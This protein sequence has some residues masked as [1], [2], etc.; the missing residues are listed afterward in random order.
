M[1]RHHH[2]SEDASVVVARRPRIVVSVLLTLIAVATA[3]GAFA[4]WPHG[5]AAAL[6]PGSAQVAVDGT[7]FPT[8]TV[9]SISPTCAG[10]GDAGAPTAGSGCETATV[11]ILDGDR[12]GTRADVQLQGPLA[13]AGISPGDQVRL[14]IAPAAAQASGDPGTVQDAAQGLAQG[15]AQEAGQGTAQDAVPAPEE[16]GAAT[17]GVS[18][19]GVVRT[20]PFL[21]WAIVFVVIIGLVGR[22]RGLLAIVG[23]GFSG[24]VVAIFT[25]PAL[26]NGSSG[27]A[28]ALVS[29]GAMLYVVLYLAHGV[30][31]RTSAALAGTLAG[32][33]ITAVIAQLAIVST[34]LSGIAD[35]GT[36]TLAGMTSHLD[37]QGLL[38]C[39]V[40]IAGLGVLND[41][42]VT[43]SSS[44]W[45]L[46]AAAPQASRRRLFAQAM[47]IGRDHIAST[48]YTIVF[49]YAGASLGVLL[50]VSVADT[51]L[52]TLLSYDDIATEIVR[53]VCSGIGLVLAIPIT[54]A[55]AVALVPPT[56]VDG[57]ERPPRDVS[58]EDM[59]KIDWLRS[60]QTPAGSTGGIPAG[61]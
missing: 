48:I 17:P 59:S 18:V 24:V 32:V 34:R 60:L 29:A 38:A 10:V 49:A 21:L 36:G 6:T 26:L 5:A 33:L 46:R 56:R 39:A 27:V 28:V 31:M 51:P 16:P 12:A 25:L 44:V 3:V 41:V 52:L 42:T 8:A 11:T 50:L 7:T 19:F 47:R 40:I 61:G 14:M 22:W 45:E 35:D 37:F 1:H 23:L 43:Q 53:A 9:Q 15:T 13:A 55:I 57:T 54:T 30:S 20:G 2:A 58:A 4:M